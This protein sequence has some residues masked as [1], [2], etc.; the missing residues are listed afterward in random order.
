MSLLTITDERSW[1]HGKSIARIVDDSSSHSSGFFPFG[2]RGPGKFQCAKRHSLTSNGAELSP[3]G[4]FFFPLFSFIFF[5]PFSASSR[6][7]NQCVAAAQEKGGKK[8]SR[9][10][11]AYL[12]FHQGN[13]CKREAN[14][15]D[16]L[17]VWNEETPIDLYH[18]SRS[19]PV[20]NRCGRIKETGDRQGRH[21]RCRMLKRC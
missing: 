21:V 6:R 19:L 3:L 16:S 17:S 4:Y 1:H 2:S 14:L 20:K 10:A 15:T 18:N 8:P 5:F 11:F 12:P 9:C 7:R 13:T